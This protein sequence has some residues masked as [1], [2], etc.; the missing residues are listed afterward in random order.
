MHTHI[1]LEVHHMSLK[2]YLGMGQIQGEK[3]EVSPHRTAFSGSS[4]MNPNHGHIFLKT[5]K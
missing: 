5:V 4:I 1:Y 3:Q 2:I